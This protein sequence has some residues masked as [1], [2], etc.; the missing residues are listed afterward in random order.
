MD[1]PIERQQQLSAPFVI[2]F[3]CNHIQYVYVHVSYTQR[4][5]YDNRASTLS[6]GVDP[7]LDD[8]LC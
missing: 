4:Q 2:E 3:E 8:P 1:T 5:H 7:N 6:I